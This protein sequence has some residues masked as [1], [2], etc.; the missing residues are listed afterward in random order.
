MG[1][2]FYP[3]AGQVFVGDFTD[4]DVPEITKVRPVIVISPK[5]P[6]R[7]ELA[8][9][10]PISTTPPQR[11]LPF[12]YRLSRN[13]APWTGPDTET[14]AKCDLVMNVALRRL[15]AFKVGRRKYEYPTL[16]P[17]DLAGVRRAVLAG[18]GLDRH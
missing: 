4:L 3:R 16:T 13:Y 12:V 1:L 11:M 5:L 17:E 9:I 7:S 6:N 2:K 8:A 10:V 14:W 18:L 15:S